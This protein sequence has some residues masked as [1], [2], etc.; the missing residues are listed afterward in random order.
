MILG[1]RRGCWVCCRESTRREPWE[2][3]GRMGVGLEEG[4]AVL[5]EKLTVNPWER[6]TEL[7]CGSGPCWDRVAEA[8][9]SARA[10]AVS[11]VP[12]IR[13]S[14]IILLCTSSTRDSQRIRGLWPPPPGLNHSGLSYPVWW[15]IG[16]FPSWT[17][18]TIPSTHCLS[19]SLRWDCR[20]MFSFRWTVD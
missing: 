11:W 18:F 12:A 15:L 20:G 10:S 16:R 8:S 9:D 6:S 7:S 1:E 13:G 5:P 2:T 4:A 14:F 19:S 17:L 3:R